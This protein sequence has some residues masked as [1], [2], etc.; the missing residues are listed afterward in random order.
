MKS[1][2]QKLLFVILILSFAIFTISLS[3]CNDSDLAP[4]YRLYLD[5]D[6]G[7]ISGKAVYKF[8]NCENNDL[9]EL[10]FSLRANAY[11]EQTSKKPV[12]ESAYSKAFY[13]GE[14]FGKTEI[15]SLLVNGESTPFNLSDDGQFLTVNQS[16]KKGQLAE[17][18]IDFK[19]TI[20]KSNLRLGVT[21]S[22]VN[23]ADFF[24]TACFFDGNE[25]KKIPYEPIGDP[26]FFDACDYEVDITLPSCY[27][28]ASSGSPTQTS[29]EGE[30]TTYSYKLQ[31]GRDFAFAIS[32]NYTVFQ[33][34][35]D[36]V[37]L[38]YY[39]LAQNGEDFLNLALDCYSFFEK[40]FGKTP[41]GTFSLAETDFIFDGMEFSGLCFLSSSLS[42]EDKKMAIVHETA[43]QWWGCTL[44]NDQFSSAYIDE[45]LCEYSTYLYFLSKDENLAK[46]IIDSA[47]SAY[48]SFFS[49]EQTLSGAID[50]TMKRDLTTYKSDYE[51]Y[52]IAYAKGLLTFYEYQQ[53]TG[54]DRTK[55]NLKKLYE[56]NY[57]G[58]IGL[59][60]IIS[61]L[62]KRAHFESFVQGKVLI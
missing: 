61:A 58:E 45:G 59:E 38:T 41:Y 60:E 43:H 54:L 34:S 27:I 32:T 47:K 4:T 26:Y 39:S 62:G 11:S 6:N 23:L 14:S 19:T 50:S 9:N 51:Y 36:G 30:K 42:D 56:N 17:I 22:G 46:T 24:P 5:Y 1:L 31:G 10:V 20:P 25:F 52:C 53:S 28:V 3:A 33:N 21:K 15:L 29:I 18:E 37:T 44:S 55:Q 7:I 48:K 49:I 13:E 35:I 2:I 12:L 40:T 8:V 16:V 57:L